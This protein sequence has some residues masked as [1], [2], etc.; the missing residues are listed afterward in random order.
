MELNSANLLCI[1]IL[2]DIT[3]FHEAFDWLLLQKHL[4]VLRLCSKF[5][6]IASVFLCCVL[7]TAGCQGYPTSWPPKLV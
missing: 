1:H 6:W 7:Q 5:K 2:L 3:S 4:R